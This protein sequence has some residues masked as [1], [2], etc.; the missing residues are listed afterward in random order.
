MTIRLKLDFPATVDVLASLVWQYGI[1]GMSAELIL[2]RSDKRVIAIAEF[3][4]H[5]DELGHQ[6][7]RVRCQMRLAAAA[8]DQRLQIR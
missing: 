8:P 6:V 2:E 5:G 4:I 3:S 1:D 7:K